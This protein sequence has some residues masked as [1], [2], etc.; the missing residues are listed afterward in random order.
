MLL[1]V[2]VKKKLTWEQVPPSV[3]ASVCVSVCASLYVCIMVF[4][5]ACVFFP[6]SQALAYTIAY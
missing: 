2:S 4:L 5:S 3:L 1:D 6:V